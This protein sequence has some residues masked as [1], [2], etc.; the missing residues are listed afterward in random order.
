MG[1]ACERKAEKGHV[2]APVIQ[3]KVWNRT[4][5]GKLKQ[6]FWTFPKNS[7]ESG[8]GGG[9]KFLDGNWVHDECRTVVDV[10]AVGA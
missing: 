2:S 8:G 3:Q 1:D 4:W 6:V 10:R 5:A 9:S 7:V